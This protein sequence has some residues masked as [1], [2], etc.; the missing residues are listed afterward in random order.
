MTNYFGTDGVRGVANRE[1]TP[2]LA[3]NLGR[4]G[5]HLLKRKAASE[6]DESAENPRIILGRD[7]RLS[8]DMLR[9][10]LG[11]GLNSAGIDV[12]DAGIVPT[13]AVAY[14]A[15]TKS[16]IGGI[17]ISASHNPVAD[18]GIKFFEANGY[19]ISDDLEAEIEEKLNQNI[20]RAEHPFIG[21]YH[22]QADLS[23]PYIDNI[24]NAITADLSDLKVVVDCAYG[25]AYNLGPKI[26]RSFGIDL[27]AIN[28][29]NNGEKINHRCG[30]TNTEQ[31]K[32]TVKEENFDLGIALD[33]D[34]DRCILVDEEGRELDGDHILCI[35][36][37]HML[38][39][40][41]L[42]NDR[43]VTTRYSNLGLQEA[44]QEAGGEVE[45]AAN[46][47]KYVL[48]KMR[49]QNLNLGGEKS[50]HIIFLDYNTS[51]DGIFTA[52]KV[53]S[54]MVREQ[55]SLKELSRQ[56]TPWPQLLTNIEV[57]HK[58]QWS[59]NDRIADTIKQAEADL[60]QGR[61]FVRASGTEPVI[62]VMLE[63][64]NRNKLERWNVKLEK[65]IE[66]ELN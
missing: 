13:P 61:V 60:E 40:D 18:N 29:E 59:Q 32:R 2:E 7:T 19:K 36:G 55:K 9:G 10:A 65:V 58:N 26:F 17:M 24:K 44:L 25:A 45:I 35:C 43:L 4:A 22:E 23:A 64:K 52:L 3:L 1:L 63:G 8:G 47:D 57:K 34:S 16:V 37:L 28:N 27:T 31:I 41:K 30:A 62:R 48:N 51:G 21:K 38:S 6:G 20:K 39:Q 11:A 53:M 56:F 50:G 49:E 14:L 46:G 33:G 66:D 15:G 12:L 5:G 42:K 54:V